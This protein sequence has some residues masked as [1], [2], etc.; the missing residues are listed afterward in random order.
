MAFSLYVTQYFWCFI[1]YWKS[2]LFDNLLSFL[3]PITVDWSWPAQRTCSEQLGW[4]SVWPGRGRDCHV[5]LLEFLFYLAGWALRG[6]EIKS[7]WWIGKFLKSLILFLSHWMAL[8][9]FN[10]ELEVSKTRRQKVCVKLILVTQVTKY[11]SYL[12]VH[13]IFGKVR[14]EHIISYMYH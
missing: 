10:L 8:L 14:Q 5:T 3:I 6:I 11:L 12:K 2:W 7:R 1:S 13:S 9:F 4:S